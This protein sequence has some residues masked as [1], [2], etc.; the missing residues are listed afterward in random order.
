[1]KTMNKLRLLKTDTRGATMVEYALLLFLV[2]VTAAAVW[3]Q[4]GPKVR[5]AGQNTGA[6]LHSD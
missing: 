4:I 6:E 3:H 5:T 2:L 1:M